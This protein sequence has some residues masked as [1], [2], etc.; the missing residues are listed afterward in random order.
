MSHDH[1]AIDMDGMSGMDG[2]DMGSSDSSQSMHMM[3][4]FQTNI[5]TSLYSAAWT[6]TTTGAYAGTC[7]FLV[8]LALGFRLLLWGKALAEA[9][10]L[11]AEIKRRYVVVQG[12]PA[13][14]E[15]I[16][17][18]GAG[19]VKKGTLVLSENGV[20][21]DV[22]VLQKR[23]S[24]STLGGAGGGGVVSAHHARPWRMSVDPLRAL[25]DTVIVGVGYML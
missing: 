22:V 11:D 4:I 19:D 24:I 5:N 16:L 8:L 21:E 3:S 7:I 12:K 14:S 6:P 15:R 17:Q 13:L 20:E 10:W 23:D 18:G 2:M 9:R 1:G 25:F